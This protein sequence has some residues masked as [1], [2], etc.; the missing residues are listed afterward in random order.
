MKKI[1][2]TLFVA[3]MA[4][5]MSACSFGSGGG[6]S[7]SGDVSVESSTSSEN[8]EECSV[9]QCTK[10]R[11]KNPTCSQ[12]GNIEYW[13]CY[14]CDKIF[15][16]I[17]ATEEL[18]IEDVTIA[19][20]DHV[21]VFVPEAAATCKEKGN[22]S[23]WTCELCQ[24]YFE[25]EDCQV[26]IEDK[27][28]VQTDKTSHHFTYTAAV[29]PNGYDNGNIEY[30]YCGDCEQ[31]FADEEGNSQITLE[32]T[33]LL[34]A[35]NI[36][37]FVVEVEA[38]REPIVLQLTDTQIIDAGQTRPG[39]GGVDYNFW[40][41]DKVNERCYNYI[42]ETVNAT[43]PDL[44]LITGDLVY[45]EFDDSGTALLSLI[46][47]MDGF[48][49]PWAPVFGNHDNESYKG[50]DWQCEQLENAEYCL[51]EQKTLTGNGNY[52][53][54]IAQGGQL[55]RV[56]Y[57]LDSNGC[58][59]ASAESI[60]N[61]HT[62][63]TAG[64]GQD[65]IN[66][67]TN[68]ITAIKA[69]VPDVKISFAYHIQQAIFAKAYEQYGFTQSQQSQDIN[70]DL[71]ANKA[72]TDFGYIG[73]QMKSAWDGNYAIFNGMKALG[74]DSIFVGHEHCNSVSVVY[75]GIRFQ[76]GQKTSEYD[77]Y[78]FLNSDGTI[79]TSPKTSASKSLMGGT[80]MKLS[81]TDG[82]IVDAYIYYCGYPNGVIDWSQWM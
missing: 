25:D 4:T 76:Y 8:N 29:E 38:G 31:Y 20:L 52:S 35:F 67:Y 36:P 69:L 61:G 3:V 39:R 11:A 30:W 79:T 14:V 47:F 53:V 50:V 57:M 22:I 75:E 40:A 55:K 45:G 33:V 81:E 24:E 74:A 73:R 23:H 70:L 16:D 51:F 59:S 82:A 27:G 43:N 1:I 58:G 28:S 62:K 44:I 54:A 18:T 46:E 26:I 6:S 10:T 9:H 68:E 17:D 2:L 56:F 5:S 41:T 42:T 80:V 63:T 77:R 13:S 32:D 71:L 49:I 7:T 64:F 19:K 78:N 37:D 48:Q 60:S 15:T 66:W 72:D 12:E 65:Q 34:S 21:S